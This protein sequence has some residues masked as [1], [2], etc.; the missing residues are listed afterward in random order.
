MRLDF[1]GSALDTDYYDSRDCERWVP[2]IYVASSTWHILL[3]HPPKGRVVSCRAIPVTD[4]SDEDGWRWRL[5]IG[6]WHLP[7]FRR[8]FRPFRP[9]YP[10]KFEIFER[11]AVL[12]CGIQRHKRGASFFG[13]VQS[14]LQE[15]GSVTLWLVR[16]A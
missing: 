11:A 10:S 12:Y 1:N 5:E 6:D 14:G 7:L 16:G 2:W 15:C 3:P 8:C 9:A 4:R 13:S